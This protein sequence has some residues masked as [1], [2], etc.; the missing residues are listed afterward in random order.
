MP[1]LDDDPGVGTVVEVVG[2]IYKLDSIVSFTSD[3]Y[4]LK[5]CFPQFDHENM[6]RIHKLQN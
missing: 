1:N 4:K 3:K 5:D 6:K 2:I